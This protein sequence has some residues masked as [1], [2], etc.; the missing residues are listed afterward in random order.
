MKRERER[1]RESIYI[2]I[3]DIHRKVFNITLNEKIIDYF[4]YIE[5]K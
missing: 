2:N 3:L 5:F 4:I 1:E